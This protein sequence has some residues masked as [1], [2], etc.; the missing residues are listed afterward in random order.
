M[1]MDSIGPI[2][3]MPDLALQEEL[4]SK[5]SI[6]DVKNVETSKSNRSWNVKISD[7]AKK[8]AEI[9]HEKTMKD[10]DKVDVSIIPDE[11]FAEIIRNNAAPIPRK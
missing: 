10:Q 11:I 7:E 1:G 2:I 3:S 6:K 5:P 8:M 4:P 9:I